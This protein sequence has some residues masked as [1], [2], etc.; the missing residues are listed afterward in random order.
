MVFRAFVSV[1]RIQELHHTMESCAREEGGSS[2]TNYRNGV[3]PDVRGEMFLGNRYGILENKVRGAT[4][5]KLGTQHQDGTKIRESDFT[6]WIIDKNIHY[7]TYT[8]PERWRGSEND[9]KCAMYAWKPGEVGG[10]LPNN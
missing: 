3:R 1:K 9:F 2:P 5:A 10:D 8:T 4:R 7:I 6:Q